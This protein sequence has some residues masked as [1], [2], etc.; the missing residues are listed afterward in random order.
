MIE[1]SI[2]NN[3]VHEDISKKKEVRM[4]MLNKLFNI[5][6]CV[7]LIIILGFVGGYV[8]G[9]SNTEKKYSD[10]TS[11]EHVFENIATDICNNASSVNRLQAE[12]ENLNLRLQQQQAENA[13]LKRLLQQEK[14]KGVIDKMGDNLSNTWDGAVAMWDDITD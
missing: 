12:V 1:E 2:K 7:T 9:A 5:V 13:E 8:F 10:N 3:G 6:I 4:K 14:D 11:I